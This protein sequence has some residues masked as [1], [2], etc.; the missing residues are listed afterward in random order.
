MMATVVWCYCDPSPKI[1]PSYFVFAVLPQV[2]DAHFPRLWALLIRS[3]SGVGVNKKYPALSLNIAR[4]LSFSS[5]NQ[6]SPKSEIAREVVSGEEMKIQTNDLK[7]VLQRS[8]VS[9]VGGERER[10]GKSNWQAGQGGG[11]EFDW[12]WG[13]SWGGSCCLL[14]A[15][16]AEGEERYGLGKCQRYAHSSGGQGRPVR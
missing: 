3:T 5:P 1:P 13:W 8:V 9:G 15:S 2:I 16:L 12:G 7:Q 6:K 4:S 10:R 11:R 14:L